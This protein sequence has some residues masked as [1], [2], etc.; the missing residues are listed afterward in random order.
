MNENHKNHPDQNRKASDQENMNAGVN[1][2]ND[3]DIPDSGFAKT[4]ET[5]EQR[6]AKEIGV[7]RKEVG[8]AKDTGALS[9][10]QDYAGGF[11]GDKTATIGTKKDMEDKVSDPHSWGEGSEENRGK[12]N[13]HST[14]K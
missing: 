1:Y 14:K 11:A 9:G 5:A 2:K 7:D 12:R 6:I 10:R 3:Q 8:K 4:D 13:D